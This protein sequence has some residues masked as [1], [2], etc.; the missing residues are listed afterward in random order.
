MRNSILKSKLI[1]GIFVLL[2]MGAKTTHAQVV[3]EYH[4]KLNMDALRFWYS[5]ANKPAYIFN[6]DIAPKG[7]CL[8]VMN[9]YLFLTWFKGGM[10]ERNLML[11]RMNLATKQWVTI[12][13]PD[14]S[15][16]YSGEK[17]G[18]DMTGAGDSHRTAAIG[19]CTIDGTVHMA[20]DM[21]VNPLNYRVSDKNI[22]F[23]PD[24]EFT[25]DHFSERRNYLKP[26]APLP[27]FTYPS[28]LTNDAGEVIVEYRLGTSR[29]GD[30]YITYYN[31]S[32]W[33][34]IILLIKGDNE[35]PQ[36]N[37]Y[38]DFSY[39]HGKMYLACGIREYGSDIT[40][41]QG[42]YFAEAGQHGNEDWKNL[43]GQTFKLPIR[44]LDQMNNFKIC[45][46]LPPG[47]DGM[48]GSPSLVVSKNGAIHMTNLLNGTGTVHYY[49]NVGSRTL[50]KADGTTPG[51]SFGADDQRVYSVN[52][53]CGKIRVQSTPEGQSNW[54]TDYV[55]SRSE[56]FGI[57]STFYY[58]SKIY[59]IA[60]EDINSDKRPMHIVILKLN[61]NVENRY[62][63]I[64]GKIE[65][66][67]YKAI[68]GAQKATA[69]DEGDG[70]CVEITENNA[71][72]EYNVTVDKADTYALRIRVASL[73]DSIKCNFKLNG[74]NKASISAG[75]T[76]GEQ[77]WK[78]VSVPI[79]L[80]A[81]PQ[82]L[83]IETAGIWNMN[84][85]DVA[86]RVLQAPT[87]SIETPTG[88]SSN[89]E[90]YKLYVRANASD[91]DGQIA[92]VKLYIDDNFVREESV[93]PYEWGSSSSAYPDELNGL[94]VGA[95]VIK[96]VATDN[97]GLTAESSFVFT[98]IDNF[99]KSKVPV[100]N[101]SAS[102]SDNVH[103]AEMAVDG[104]YDNESYWL[105]SGKYASLVLDLCN[106]YDISNVGIAWYFGNR[107]TYSFDIEISSDSVSWTK[108]FTGKSS[109]STTESEVIAL[110][111]A[112]GR[113]LKYVG[114]GNTSNSTNSIIECEIYG[115]LAIENALPKTEMKKTGSV[116][117][118][119]T[120]GIFTISLNQSEQVNIVIYNMLGK[121]VYQ[122]NNVSGSL[123]LSK[124]SLFVSGTYFIVVKNKNQIKGSHIFNVL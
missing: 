82:T 61:G 6:R 51:V 67:N 66:E 123:T 58:D 116:F 75:P 44:G 73:S 9:G 83:R 39:Q 56:R 42:F 29:Q 23:A 90:D 68:V 103:I 104:S 70:E 37:Q 71:I 118:N 60:A 74:V 117:P 76:G 81:G 79:K 20:Y 19:I 50:I 93:A 47:H 78:T 77:V 87:I 26:G 18:V 16:L 89:F 2:F 31:G 98:V 27:N 85:M 3:Q 97:E 22:A 84:W 109:G 43:Q 63:S 11:S 57:M 38:G 14:K 124:N 1:A 45:E 120:S 69:T 15:T 62:S 112:T 106:Q 46:P 41:N 55:W 25:I 54:R 21:H 111:N 4:A 12:E 64:P 35:N 13:F 80:S 121:I 92:N 36:F 72:M 48:T 59:I 33:S 108:V 53:V 40:Y 96:V 34:D 17:N 110:T 102:T 107:R 94:P 30:K 32:E 113:Y 101:V 115:Q 28:F 8:K 95:H 114:L 49:T 119:P 86:K 7:D 24:S 99:F 100:C 65:A 10:T 5:D 122:Q 52:F 105:G 91:D 88:D